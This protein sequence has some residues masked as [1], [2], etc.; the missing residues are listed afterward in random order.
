M[1]GPVLNTFASSAELASALASK[2]AT[3]L[4]S[5]IASSQ[6]ARLVVS[7]GRTPLRFFAELRSEDLD[8]ASIRVFLADER[9][10]PATSERS[11]A[12]F[13]KEHLLPAEAHFSEL[14]GTD[15]KPQEAASALANDVA[16]MDRPFDAVI[17]GMGKD[18]HTASLFPDAPE[19][20][21]A[22]SPGADAAIV[23]SPTSQPE[24]RLSLT[25]RALINT[26]FLAL[27]IEGTDK[28]T[29]YNAAM[30]NGPEAEMPVRAILR[31]DIQ[32]TQVY[33]C[34]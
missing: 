18:G 10:V 29:V 4:R 22:L 31:N 15:L 25:P 14:Y 34:P 16:G 21:Q 7:G 12:A 33:W 23:L 3:H 32:A 5:A 9:W 19:I 30:G 13:V 24:L 1:S 11:N 8:W 28:R 26:N 6:L 20:A 17:L 27:H 2:T